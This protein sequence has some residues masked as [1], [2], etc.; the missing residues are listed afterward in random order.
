ML[1]SHAIKL[2]GVGLDRKWVSCV[3]KGASVLNMLY[4]I[5]NGS[6]A[7]GSGLMYEYS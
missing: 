7:F 1:L 5:H 6:H 2:E 4:Y 3:R